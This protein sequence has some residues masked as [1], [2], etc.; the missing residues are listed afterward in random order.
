MIDLAA[1]TQYRPILRPATN[2]RVAIIGAGPAGLAAA[3]ELTKLG[4]CC[5]VIDSHPQPGG[6]LRYGLEEGKLPAS[7][8]DGELQ[9]LSDLGVTWRMSTRIPEDLTVESLQ[10]EFDALA[11]TA[12]AGQLP[13]TDGLFLSASVA[14]QRPHAVQAI[15]DGKDLARQVNDYLER[16]P[17]AAHRRFAV[18]LGALSEREMQ[19][20]MASATSSAARAPTRELSPADA[21]T[22]A[23]RCMLCGCA[24]TDSCRLRR[25]AAEYGAEPS[26]YRG[27][28]RPVTRIT[29]H[30]ELIFEEGKC[31]S[32]GLCIAIAKRAGEPLGLCFVRRGFDVSVSAPLGK[33]WSQALT[34]AAFEA[35]DACP[36]GAIHRR[37]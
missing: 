35:A 19:L 30:P 34:T 14:S 36:T 21:A 9:L 31:I 33:D 5:T 7:V 2:R 3:Y 24:S 23:E 12:P 27:D 18:R 16:K 28:R 17:H 37:S 25:L 13:K 8:L 11:I 26:R 15:A 10:R 4:H 20:F 22:Q 29:T 1:P 6:T 32:C